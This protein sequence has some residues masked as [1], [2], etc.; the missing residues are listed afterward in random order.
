MQTIIEHLE[1]IIPIGEHCCFLKEGKRLICP[2]LKN[3]VGIIGIPPK[4][5]E[6]KDFYCDMNEEDC[7]NKK[8]C[9]IN[10]KEER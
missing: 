6:L 5:K 9:E 3:W 4:E 1:S 2:F 10:I 7:F 8:I